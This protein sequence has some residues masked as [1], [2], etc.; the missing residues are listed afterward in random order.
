MNVDRL[1]SVNDVLTASINREMLAD[2]ALPT[3]LILLTVFD[4]TVNDVA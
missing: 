2:R 4:E 1:H 3:V